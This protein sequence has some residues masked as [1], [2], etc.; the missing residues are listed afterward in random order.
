MRREDDARSIYPRRR[1]AEYFGEVSHVLGLIKPFSSFL[2]P[3]FHIATYSARY[4]CPF[5][6]FI[7]ILQISRRAQTVRS[8]LYPCSPSISP[9]T[10]ECEFASSARTQ[11][12]PRTTACARYVTSK[13]G[14]TS[15]LV[16]WNS[17]N[18]VECSAR[19]PRGTRRVEFRL[20][21]M[22]P[23]DDLCTL[24]IAI[25]CSLFGRSLLII[26]MDIAYTKKNLY[27]NI[28]RDG[29]LLSCR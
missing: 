16:R 5:S 17:D 25:P 13:A 21:C 24:R 14:F 11:N 9:W 12:A 26:V 2:F 4:S 10:R 20:S 6:A 8:P 18:L 19:N 29:V 15:E 23:P 3:R 7:T 1:R 22:W 28:R 27:K